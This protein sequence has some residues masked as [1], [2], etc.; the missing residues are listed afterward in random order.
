MHGTLEDTIPEST[1]NSLPKDYEFMT[2]TQAWIMG[3]VSNGA[4]FNR[5]VENRQSEKELQET[6]LSADYMTGN[7]DDDEYFVLYQHFFKEKSVSRDH[8]YASMAENILKDIEK[9]RKN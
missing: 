3:R 4:Y 2:P 9:K 1:D 8:I 6:L 5:P 7:I